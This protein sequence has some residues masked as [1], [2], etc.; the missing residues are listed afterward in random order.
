M[1]INVKWLVV[2]TLWILKK[3]K[4]A[5]LDENQGLIFFTPAIVP[6]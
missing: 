5:N 3:S 6:Q 1:F 4:H 2:L